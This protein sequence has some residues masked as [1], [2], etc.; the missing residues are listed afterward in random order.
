MKSIHLVAALLLSSLVALA[1]KKDI[2]IEIL[3]KN[4]EGKGSFRGLSVV[5]DN[6]VWASGTGGTVVRSVDGGKNWKFMQIPGNRD[7][8]DIEAFDSS[9]AI[10][11]AVATPALVLKTK[12]GGKTWDTVY[13]RNLQGMFLDAM[14]FKPNGKEGVIVGDPIN[15]RFWLIKTKDGGDSWQDEP[16][17][18]MPVAQREEACFAASGSNIQYIPND[19]DCEFAFVSGGSIARVFKL[20]GRDDGQNVTYNLPINQ[21]INSAG[22]FSLA[23]Y[24]K[25]KM[26]VVGG[27]YVNDIQAYD[28]AVYTK[29]GFK[30]LKTPG[31]TP[32]QGFRSCVIYIAE[33]FMLCVGTSGVDFTTNGGNEWKQ[34]TKESFHVCAKAKKGNAVF[35][36]GNFGRIARVLY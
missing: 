23:V 33:K 15:E 20:S 36:A 26:Y 32:P 19:P 14:A 17:P 9:T 4:K 28:N 18:R 12:N 7:F 11:M 30:S 3:L 21:G 8:R 34:F 1:Q 27:N 6:V 24:D 16:M 10:V 31:I 2:Q 25:D 22:A 35:M 13:F 29:N 5:D